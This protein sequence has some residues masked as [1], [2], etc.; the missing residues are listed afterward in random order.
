[1]TISEMQARIARL[2][3]AGKLNLYVAPFVYLLMTLTVAFFLVT[4]LSSGESRDLLRLTLESIS[5]VVILVAI[6]IARI[7]GKRQL[8]EA[9]ELRK[10]IAGGIRGK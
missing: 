5:I 10:E 9:N 1:M 3:A 6:L 4:S 8:K 2:E 7:G